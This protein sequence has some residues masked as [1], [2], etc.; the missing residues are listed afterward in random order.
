MK[1]RREIKI[2]ELLQH[3]DRL[4]AT[5]P[6]PEQRSILEVSRQ[7]VMDELSRLLREDG[8]DIYQSGGNL[9]AISLAS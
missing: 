7:A 9:G 5:T 2:E 8:L 4:D 3:L 6:T 1:T